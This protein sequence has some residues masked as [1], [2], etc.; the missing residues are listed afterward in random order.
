MS[1]QKADSS[2][3][4]NQRFNHADLMPQSSPLIPCY[5]A[6]LNHRLAAVVERHFTFSQ[7][8]NHLQVVYFGQKNLLAWTLEEES[9]DPTRLPNAYKNPLAQIT[10]T[11]P[12]EPA[13]D[14]ERGPNSPR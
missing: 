7:W 14:P 11:V 1:S 2:T 12:S 8:A 13:T 6:D 4:K 9:S 5:K 3:T 10:L